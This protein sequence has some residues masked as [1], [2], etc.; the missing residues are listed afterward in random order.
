MVSG[1]CSAVSACPERYSTENCLPTLIDNH[2][3]G[4]LGMA[5]QL[6]V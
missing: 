6:C 5:V 3:S 1:V 2:N 4:Y